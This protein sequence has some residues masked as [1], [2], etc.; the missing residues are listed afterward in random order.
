MIDIRT[1]REQPDEVKRQIEHYRTTDF[2][3]LSNAQLADE[4]TELRAVRVEQGRL[5]MLAM[6]P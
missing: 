4:L 6:T 5:H 1:I 3:S 2:A